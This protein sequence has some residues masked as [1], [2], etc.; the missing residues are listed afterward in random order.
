MN[1]SVS[2]VK[3]MTNEIV[4]KIADNTSLPNDIVDLLKKSTT[5]QEI[6]LDDENSIMLLFSEIEEIKKKMVVLNDL[7]EEI[8]RLW[9][10]KEKEAIMKKLQR[11]KSIH[12]E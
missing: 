10:E 12:V 7:N 3:E 6:H 8:G 5:K 2:I 11:A 1:E 9:N 4:E